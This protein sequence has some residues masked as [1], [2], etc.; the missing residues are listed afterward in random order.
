MPQEAPK[1]VGFLA[2]PLRPGRARVPLVP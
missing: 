2:E 1:D